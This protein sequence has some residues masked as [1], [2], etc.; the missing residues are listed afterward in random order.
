MLRIV[1]EEVC[2]GAQLETREI[3]GKAHGTLD[4]QEVRVVLSEPNE[5]DG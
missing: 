2:R 4:L 1:A 3:P 5:A